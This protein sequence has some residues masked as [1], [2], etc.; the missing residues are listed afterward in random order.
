MAIL[1]LIA[2]RDVAPGLAKTLVRPCIDGCV[3]AITGGA[4]AYAVLA[5]EGGI[6]PLTSL[7]AV[8]TQGLIAGIV[9]LIVSA[10]ALFFLENEEFRIVTSALVR[11]ASERDTRAE[12]LKPSAEEP[13]RS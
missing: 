12:A 9:G 4:S 7:T 11:L 5:F 6:A 3:A 2:L 10:V 13:I 1:S 8:F